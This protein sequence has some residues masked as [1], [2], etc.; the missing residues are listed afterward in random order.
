MAIYQALKGKLVPIESTSF[1]DAGVKERAD[2][3]QMLRQQIEVIAPDTLVIAEE[4]GDWDDSRRRI[5]LLA[6]DKEANLVVIELKRT[7]DGGHMELQALRYA[8]MVSLLTFD[9]AVE[10]YERYLAKIGEELDARTHILEFLDWEDPVAAEFPT[11]VRIVL[12]AADFSKEITTAALWLNEHEIDIR[13]VRL[14][15]H[16]DAGRLLIDVQQV[17]PLPEAESYQVKI[18]Q[19][20]SA[21]RAARTQNRDMTRYDV[22]VGAKTFQNLPKRRAIY[23]VIRALCDAGVDPD[24]IRNT[25]PWKTTILIPLE[26]T[27]DEEE[28][29][30][31]LAA[32]MIEQGRQPQTYRFYTDNSDLIHA[33]GKTYAATKMWGERTTGCLPKRAKSNAFWWITFRKRRSINNLA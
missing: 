29:D 6:I 19:K 23:Q 14:R 16:N 2:I 22:T 15:P 10:T 31:S 24:G 17:I 28:F 30:K 21:E 1:A 33:N 8:A 7:D 5:D 25:V 13:C 20:K 12:A 9:E 18:R 4:F 32:Q 3:Q 27:L 26:G 11:D